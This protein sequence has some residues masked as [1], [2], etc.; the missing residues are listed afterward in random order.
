MRSDDGTLPDIPPA[1]EGNMEAAMWNG[2]LFV[3]GITG[4]RMCMRAGE[5]KT[6]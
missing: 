3:V 5:Y 2:I 6:A 4:T 1:I